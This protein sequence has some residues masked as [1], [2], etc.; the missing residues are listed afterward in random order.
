MSLMF[1]E[2]VVKNGYVRMG[3]NLSF[4]N[5]CVK[6]LM[7]IVCMYFVE[8]ILWFLFVDW[9]GVFDFVFLVMICF[10]C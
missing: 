4:V 6:E 1:I 2:I 9:L 5:I 7:E 3:R 10:L 8:L